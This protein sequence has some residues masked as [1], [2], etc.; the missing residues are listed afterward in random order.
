MVM[1]CSWLADSH[2]GCRVAANQSYSCAMPAAT[3]G[4]ALR[5]QR[6]LRANRM[7]IAHRLLVV[8]RLQLYANRATPHFDGDIQF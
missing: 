6:T 3:A 7:Q 1:R 2:I 5:E 4:D 8:T